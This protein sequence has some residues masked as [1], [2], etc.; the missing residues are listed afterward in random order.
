MISKNNIGNIYKADE[1]SNKVLLNEEEYDNYF[2]FQ[3]KLQRYNLTLKIIYRG[4]SRA[5]FIKKI[6]KQKSASDQVIPYSTF[7]I[8]G[9]KAKSYF[10]DKSLQYPSIKHFNSLNFIDTIFAKLK[11]IEQ[12]KQI[13]LNGISKSEFKAKIENIK[14]ESIQKIILNYYISILHTNTSEVA[15][16]KLYSNLISCT[17]N[18]EIADSYSD[19]GFIICFWL[20]NPV[21]TEGINF[22]N[23]RYYQKQ[24]DQFGLPSIAHGLHPNER[25]ISIFSAIFPHRILYVE[26]KK[27]GEFIVNPHIFRKDNITAIKNGLQ[28]DQSDF[29]QKIEGIYDA[30]I[31]KS[32]KS[33]ISEEFR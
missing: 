5:D 25:E 16:L 32:N 18:K 14:N 15:E 23:L 31:W 11:V 4:E 17:F 6:S 29:P 9:S 13:N 33:I 26:D 20:N 7:F 8:I 30:F 1:W 2:L 12:S 21:E 24:L 19:D 10:Q 3:N 22:E 28:I 27:S